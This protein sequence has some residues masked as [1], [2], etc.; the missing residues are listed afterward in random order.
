MNEEEF[1]QNI[2]KATEHYIKEYNLKENTRF[3]FKLTQ[4]TYSKNKLT[5][6]AQK[7][8]EEY[9]SQ[10][11][12]TKITL[13]NSPKKLY[14]FIKKNYNNTPLNFKG[15]NIK[16]GTQLSIHLIDKEINFNLIQP[17]NKQLTTNS[18]DNRQKII[19]ECLQKQLKLKPQDKIKIIQTTNE[20]Y[21]VGK[22]ES[23]SGKAITSKNIYTSYWLEHNK[24]KGYYLDYIKPI[25]IID[26]D[27][28]I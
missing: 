2:Q 14:N 12:N 23:A 25:K 16:L 27:K 26:L 10:I 8:N 28:E 15:L 9:Y 24:K 13:T 7:W 6:N 18:T 21:T 11:D 1:S 17:I 5:K 3:Y 19:L 4:I 22:H 20:R